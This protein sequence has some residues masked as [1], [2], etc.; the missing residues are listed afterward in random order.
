MKK[1]ISGILQVI[2]SQFLIG[3]LYIFV[4]LGGGFG[5]YNL[6]FFRVL[7][8]FLFLGVLFIFSRKFYLVKLNKSKY[9]MFFFGF[10]HAI[11][12]ILSFI[13]INNLSV[14]LAVLLTATI[15]IWMVIFSHILL[16][17]KINYKIVYSIIL[18]FIGLLL[19]VEFK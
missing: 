11:T 9:K 17:E 1:Q 13:S 7:L 16:K 10:L 19:V 8:A 6:V 2:L 18:S 5:V 15:S 12:I 3:F 4:K 14:S